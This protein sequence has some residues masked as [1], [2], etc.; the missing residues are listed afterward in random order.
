[1]FGFLINR[2]FASADTTPPPVLLWPEVGRSHGQGAAAAAHG[3]F[4]IP[5]QLWGTGNPTGRKELLAAQKHWEKKTFLLLGRQRMPKALSLPL[6]KS[7][8]FEGFFFFFLGG[9]RG[10]KMLTLINGRPTRL[11]G[12]GLALKAWASP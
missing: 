12:K 10:A 1:M 4:L 7:F 6:P 8:T 9:E 2:A 11:E 3:L 5:C